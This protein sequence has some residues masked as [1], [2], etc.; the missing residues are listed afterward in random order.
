[1]Y[2]NYT[3]LPSLYDLSLPVSGT[4]P[5]VGTWTRVSTFILVRK[6]KSVSLQC[7]RF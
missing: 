5:E 1:M 6:G 4:V 3:V 7:K 2:K